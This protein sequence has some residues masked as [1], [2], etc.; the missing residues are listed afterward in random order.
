M[1]IEI[2]VP[3]LGESVVEATVSKWLKQKGDFVQ[4]DEA[5][6]ELETEKVS[7]EVPSPV[8][9]IL[10]DIMANNGED[11]QVGEV[12]ASINEN[13]K[14]GKANPAGA[15]ATIQPAKMEPT[16]TAASTKDHLSPAPA[17]VAREHNIDTGN[18]TATGPK[19]NITKADVLKVVQALEIAPSKPQDV[20]IT[21]IAKPLVADP[22]GE[23]RV[24]MPKLRKVIARRLKDAQNTAALLT[25]FNE[26]DM[27][28]LIE[29]RSQHKE[30]FE[31]KHG[32]KLGFMSFFVKAVIDG[33]KET[34]NV[35][36]MIDG[37]DLVYRNY[38]DIGIAVGS[39]QGLVVPVIRDANSMSF[40]DIELQISDFG[41]RAQEGKLLLE[42]MTG[43]T[44]TVTNGGVFGSLLSTPIVN[45]PQS[46]ILGMHKIQ[47]RPICRDGEIVAAPMMYIAFT[48]D[49]RIIDG[50]EAV[51][52]LVRIKQSLE[53]PSRL[54]LNI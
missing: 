54:L 50:R 47:H 40:A 18:I 38:Y 25:T 29:L 32:S 9:G 21:Q 27:S 15:T 34:P 33:L 14:A 49:H 36:A 11:V 10:E 20:Q 16:K 7:I 53:D 12:L 13:A 3:M 22:R 26:I 23:E 5:L 44:F 48:Y 31:K 8:A 17:R 52:F 43:G 30:L 6:V 42:E 41:K 35:N 46:G 4:I 37:D 2:K 19:D 39:A 24:R 45:P 1:T 51:T 28:K